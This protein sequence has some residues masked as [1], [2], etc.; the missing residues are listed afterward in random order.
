MC[1]SIGALPLPEL[2]PRGPSA[3]V[4]LRPSFLP[5]HHQRNPHPGQSQGGASFLLVDFL[6]CQ[7]HGPQSDNF[8]FST[9]QKGPSSCVNNSY[10]DSRLPNRH[11]PEQPRLSGLTRSATHSR[12]SGKHL[13]LDSCTGKRVQSSVVS[14]QSRIAECTYKPISCQPSSISSQKPFSI[15]PSSKILFCFIIHPSCPKDLWQDA[16]LHTLSHALWGFSSG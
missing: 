12:Q 9:I 8:S 11:Y 1:I 7:Q 4:L 15:L 2:F 3:S 14:S 6:S 5:A 10:V 16:I 13:H